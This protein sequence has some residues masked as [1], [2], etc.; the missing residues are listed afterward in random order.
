MEHDKRAAERRAIRVPVVCW[1]ALNGRPDDSGFHFISHDLSTTGLSFESRIP[2]AIDSP[3]V[4]EI[5]LP[6]KGS[7]VATRLRVTRIE[8]VLGKE[9]YLVGTRFVEI[10]EEDRDR[11]LATLDKVDLYSIIRDA[12]SVGASD[13]HL[14]V[15]R[16]PVVR[17]GGKLHHLKS[18]PVDDGQIKAMMYPLLSAKQTADLENGLEL[19]FA[20]SPGVKTRFRV[21]LH[22]QKGFLEAALR[23]VPAY[24]KSFEE[25]GLPPD[26][27]ERLCRTRAGLILVAGTTGSGKTTTVSSMVDFINRHLERVIITIEDPVEFTH[28][29]RKSIIKQRE[30]GTDTRSYAE[31][32]KRTLR[33]DP[34]VI[35]VGELLDRDGV[36]AA[37]RAAETGHLVISTVHAPDS[38]QAIERIVNLF[39]PEHSVALS[40]QIA[41]CLIGI[42][43]QVLIPTRERKR[44]LAT[45]LLLSNHAV[46]NLIRE[47]RY[48]QLPNCIQT[49]RGT[50][51]YTLQSR[52]DELVRK[53]VIDDSVVREFAQAK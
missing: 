39:P 31:A 2:Y 25:L 4:A 28:N 49:G 11:I 36:T 46:Q 33:Q 53:G 35:V 51:M 15:G 29:S 18:N 23:A 12:V 14:S 45:E 41:S 40:Q 47:Q 26:S 3:L 50:G 32:L 43:F 48:T 5:Y 19:D 37:L 16:P 6:G 9:G 27:L 1:S 30:L 7:P 42:L 8:T 34:D 24:S 22:Y 44:V 52:L 20:F 21:N 38:A 13:L 10:Q 17:V